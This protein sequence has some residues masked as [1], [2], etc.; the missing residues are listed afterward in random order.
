MVNGVEIVQTPNPQNAETNCI[1]TADTAS[2]DEACSR[3][4]GNNVIVAD[5][6]LYIHEDCLTTDFGAGRH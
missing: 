5:V 1:T 2:R 6:D 4:T 3:H